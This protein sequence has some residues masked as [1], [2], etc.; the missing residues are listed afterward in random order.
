MLLTKIMP[1]TLQIAWRFI[2]S[3]KRAMAMTLC[4]IVFGVGFFIVTQAQTSGF[5]SFF[6]RTILGTNGAIR[7]EDRFQ[8]T[9]ESAAVLGADGRDTGFRVRTDS[10]HYVE[11]VDFPDEIRAALADYRDITGISEV[12]EGRGSAASGFRQQSARVFGIRLN[13]HLAV[14]DLGNQVIFGDLQDFATDPN[15]ALVAS[16]LAERLNLRVG[17]YVTLQTGAPGGRYRVAGIFETGVEQ[18]DRT[19]VYLDITE[20]RSLMR[21][22]YGQAM[23]QIGLRDPDRAPELA[24]QMQE[25]LHHGVVSWQYRE[26]VWLDVFKALRLSSALTVSTIILI[27]GLGMFNTLAMMVMEKTREIAIL[28]SMGYSRKDVSQIFLW[29]GL[30][31]LSVGTLLGW[32]LGAAAT[33]GVSRIPLRIRGI[34]AT[35]SFVVSWDPMHYL[36]AALVAVLVVMVASYLPAR[37]AARLEPGSIIRGA[38]A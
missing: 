23:L 25:Q 29:Q 17:D 38:S 14:S 8:D 36:A 31:I 22:P 24:E 30:I 28:R 15:A 11:G 32:C 7:I 26:R 20:A 34:F 12:V 35:D 16:R 9:L 21:K 13:D 18:I 2:T 4:G 1:P 37:R 33:W 27:S 10:G 3:R 5:E 6:I 19:Y